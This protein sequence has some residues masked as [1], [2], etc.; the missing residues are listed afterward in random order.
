MNNKNECRFCLQALKD[1]PVYC[2]RCGA[3][4]V[5]RTI[6]P[7]DEGI[8]ALGIVIVLLAVVLFSEFTGLSLALFWLGGM[9]LT[10]NLN[11]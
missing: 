8:R 9:V 4:L 7:I 2:H 1:N 3:L 10:D 5:D 11:V 6:K